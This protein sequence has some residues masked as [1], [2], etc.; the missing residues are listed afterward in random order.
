MAENAP[1][2]VHNALGLE[3][4]IA[5]VEQ[6]AKLQS[7]CCEVIDTL[8]TMRSSNI[9]TA[10][11]S[12]R[13]AVFDRQIDKILGDRHVTICDSGPMLLRE[14]ESRRAQF[15]CQL[16]L[17]DLLQKSGPGRIQHG[18]CAANVGPDIAFSRSLFAYSASICLHLRKTLLYASCQQTIT[19]RLTPCSRLTPACAASRGP[20]RSCT[21]EPL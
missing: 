17:V 18:E 16:I 2:A 4:R 1:Q 13:T 10:F 6:Q 7:G 8:E 5:E 14:G 15:K 20:G 9:L 3:A 21:F 12:T 11:S 19:K